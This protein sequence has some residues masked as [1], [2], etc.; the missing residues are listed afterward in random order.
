VHWE[1]NPYKG[2]RPR[3]VQRLCRVSAAERFEFQCKPRLAIG[4][5][6]N[7]NAKALR[8]NR[9]DTQLSNT[10]QGHKQR[11]W[12]MHGAC[13]PQ[14]GGAQQSLAKRELGYKGCR[15]TCRS[16]ISLQLN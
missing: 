14:T 11:L 9:K 6:N 1:T 13:I 10:E 15:V 8:A 12:R 16:S 5:D 7:P 2:M 4:A 3:C